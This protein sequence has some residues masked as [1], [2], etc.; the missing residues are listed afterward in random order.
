MAKA[1][2]SNPRITPDVIETQR[3]ISGKIAMFFMYVGTPVLMLIVAFFAWLM[4]KVV[5]A[6]I[7]YQQAAL[8]VTLAW[9]PR[10]VQSLTYTV[11]MLVMDTTNVTSM[12]S[13]SASPAR[14]MDPDT[15][16]RQLYNLMGR[17]DLFTLWVTFLIG[18]GIAVIGKVPRTKG[19]IAAA[20]VWVIGTLP[21]LR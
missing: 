1:A 9:I 14:F 12:Y 11:Q 19:Y 6:K 13:L 15:A 21:M 20:L 3:A 16:Q 17:L 10:L 7:T 4:A 2:A 8:I 5:S 18:V